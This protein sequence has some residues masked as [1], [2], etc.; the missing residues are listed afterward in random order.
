MF[1][2][3]NSNFFANNLFL[4]IVINFFSAGR[5]CDCHLK[6]KDTGRKENRASTV[7]QDKRFLLVLVCHA[8]S[9]KCCTCRNILSYTL[10]LFPLASKYPTFRVLTRLCLCHLKVFSAS[11]CSD[12]ENQNCACVCVGREREF[13]HRSSLGFPPLMMLL[14]VMNVLLKLINWNRNV[15][16]H[17]CASW[18]INQDIYLL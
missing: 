8:R 5:R 12:S 6:L 15:I 2:F 10:F 18:L 1:P 14:D 3:S 11:C 9:G 17:I 4:D 16:Y 13:I 7:M